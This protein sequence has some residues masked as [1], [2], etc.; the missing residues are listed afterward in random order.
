[1]PKYNKD[2]LLKEAGKIGSLPIGTP[3][4]KMKGVLKMKDVIKRLKDQYK[5]FEN[6][7]KRLE[8]SEDGILDMGLACSL[9]DSVPYLI[10]KLEEQQ[11]EIDYLKETVGIYKASDELVREQSKKVKYLFPLET[12]AGYGQLCDKVIEQQKEIDYHKRVNL[13]AIHIMTDKQNDKLIKTL[14]DKEK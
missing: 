11:K 5:S 6:E 3:L 2:L 10:E 12:T 1:M 9:A 4:P 8:E 7:S 14:E 13:M